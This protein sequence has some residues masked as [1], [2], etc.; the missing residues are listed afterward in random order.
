[1]QKHM[2]SGMPAGAGTHRPRLSARVR[3]RPSLWS[4]RTAG[5]R[6]GEREGRAHRAATLYADDGCTAPRAHREAGRWAG[7][8]CS[9]AAK[10]RHDSQRGD[11]SQHKHRGEQP[12]Q[13]AEQGCAHGSMQSRCS[14]TGKLAARHQARRGRQRRR[15][16][17][18]G[19]GRPSCWILVGVGGDGGW[20]PRQ[21]RGRARARGDIGRL[22]C[23][24]RSFWNRHHASAF[25]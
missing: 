22:H 9:S 21:P 6:R 4:G 10:H 18:R 8:G 1:M 19:R 12:C 7:R 14:V 20:G 24:V 5:G 13:Q 3:C 17:G 15:Q 2:I 16:G 25:A 11:V 23:S